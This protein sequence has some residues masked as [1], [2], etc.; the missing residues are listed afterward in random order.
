MNSYKFSKGEL[1]FINGRVVGNIKATPSMQQA[2]MEMEIDTNLSDVGPMSIGEVIQF[3]WILSSVTF[4]AGFIFGGLSFILGISSPDPIEVLAYT[5]KGLPAPETSISAVAIVLGIILIASGIVGACVVFNKV[6][7]FMAQ[8][9][10][11][12]QT[13][14]IPY[15]KADDAEVLKGFNSELRYSKE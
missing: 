12:G 1:S 11:G 6:R 9:S 3:R 10:N 7:V 8:F 4:C 15:L 14:F 5:S 2:P 13:V